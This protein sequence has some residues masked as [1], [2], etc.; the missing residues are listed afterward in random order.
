MNIPE[1]TLTE[2]ER[3]TSASSTAPTRD[4]LRDRQSIKCPYDPNFIPN[5]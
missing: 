4:G 3:T 5:S 1:D 2:S